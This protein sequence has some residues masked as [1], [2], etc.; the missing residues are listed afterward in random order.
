VLLE[1]A[2]QVS[3]VFARSARAIGR[4]L[5]DAR[6]SIG[7]LMERALEEARF[8]VLDRRN[9][10]HRGDLLAPDLEPVVEGGALR[11]RGEVKLR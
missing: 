3:R 8:G 10:Q 6:Q 11:T 4:V 2:R 7:C 1:L 5:S 9:R